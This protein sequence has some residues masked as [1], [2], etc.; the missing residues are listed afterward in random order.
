[1]HRHNQSTHRAVQNPD[2]TSKSY[3]EVLIFLTLQN[4]LWERLAE[5]VIIS[6]I[7]AFQYSEYLACE[8]HK[9]FATSGCDSFWSA[10]AVHKMFEQE[11]YR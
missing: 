3:H 10:I 1:M 4:L 6:V 2:D 11:D 7:F 8:K 5:V 9:S